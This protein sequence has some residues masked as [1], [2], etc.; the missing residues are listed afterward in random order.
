[1]SPLKWAIFGDLGQK[2][3]FLGHFDPAFTGPGLKTPASSGLL[4]QVRASTRP[5]WIKIGHFWSFLS[6]LV[7]NPRLSERRS[8]D[9]R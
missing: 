4:V 2:W 7:K 6:I 3:P 5:K 8:V 1:M 9:V